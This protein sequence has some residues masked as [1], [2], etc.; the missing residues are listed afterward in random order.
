RITVATARREDDE[1]RTA[2]QHGDSVSA[3]A[4]AR[5]SIHQRK[6]ALS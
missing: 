3:S 6:I 4:F 5:F 2:K 1:L